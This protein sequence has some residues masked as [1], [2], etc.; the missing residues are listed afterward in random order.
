M[1][2][3]DLF[4]NFDPYTPVIIRNNITGE[5]L[6]EL[7][8]FI[9]LYNSDNSYYEKKSVSLCSINKD[10]I[11]DIKID[12]RSELEKFMYEKFA[13]ITDYCYTNKIDFGKVN[14]IFKFADE[15]C[16]IDEELGRIE[17]GNWACVHPVLLSEGCG[18]VMNSENGI[19]TTINEEFGENGFEVVRCYFDS[20]T[21]LPNNFDFHTC[22]YLKFDNATFVIIIVLHDKE[23]GEKNNETD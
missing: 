5:K 18:A 16:I 20:T 21:Y 10:G 12:A 2:V 15:N 7:N 22:E 1:K 13:T 17:K 9:E 8:K 19:L 11:L 3:I 4:A 14:V 6:C 23:K